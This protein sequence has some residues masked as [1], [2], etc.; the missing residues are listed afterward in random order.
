MPL[1][2]CYARPGGRPRVT[3]SAIC[4]WTRAPGRAGERTDTDSVG[5]ERSADRP[6]LLTCHFKYQLSAPGRA[7]DRCVE[8]RPEHVLGDRIRRE[9]AAGRGGGQRLKPHVPHF[10]VGVFGELA[11]RPAR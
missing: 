8:D 2:C 9:V 6:G 7:A 1:T 3:P 10:S 5:W 4:P 11:T